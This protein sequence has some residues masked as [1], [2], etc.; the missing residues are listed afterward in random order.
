MPAHI[1]KHDLP[2]ACE[3]QTAP[4]RYIWDDKTPEPATLREARQNAHYRKGEVVYAE[5]HGDLRRC[6]VHYVGASFD[7]YGD[8]RPFFVVLPE[9]A[10]GRFGTRSARIYP[11]HIQR[12]YV[13]AGWASDIPADA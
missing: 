13:M 12:G 6:F 2:P 5:V 9:R 11:G 3:F 10:D 8:P 7:R 4:H 1:I